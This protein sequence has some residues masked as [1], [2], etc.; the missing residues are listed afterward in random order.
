MEIFFDFSAIQINR[1]PL[2]KSFKIADSNVQKE[3]ALTLTIR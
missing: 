3:F 2:K 1:I